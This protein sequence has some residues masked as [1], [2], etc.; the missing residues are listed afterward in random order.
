MKKIIY[1]FLLKIQS[2]IKVDEIAY[3]SIKD[4]YLE[5][6]SKIDT[7]YIRTD[8]WMKFHKQNKTNINKEPLLKKLTDNKSPIYISGLTHED[9]TDT[10]NK[11]NVNGMFL[12]P[13]IKENKVVGFLDILNVNKPLQLTEN[14]RDRILDLSKKYN[15]YLTTNDYI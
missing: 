10:L 2:E 6:I 3:H 9:N 12:V 7:P 4:D 13:F 11:F 14:E 1:E 15:K 8:D 5:P